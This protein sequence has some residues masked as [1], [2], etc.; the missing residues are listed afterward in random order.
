MR[1]WNKNNSPIGGWKYFYQDSYGNTYSVFAE[2]YKNLVLSVIYDMQTNG[3]AFPSDLYL[4][5]ED[6]ICTRQPVGNCIFEDKPGDNITKLIH[7]FAGGV[8]RTAARIGLQTNLLKRAKECV[9]C[10]ARR[11]RLNN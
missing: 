4:Y 11:V 1:L 9:T 6:Q 7:A 5:I 10:S 3:I 8:D 2:S